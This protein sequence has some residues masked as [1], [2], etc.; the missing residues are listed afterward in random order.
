VAQ[1]RLAALSYA[2]YG[3]LGLGRFGH[4]YGHGVGLGLGH[5]LYRGFH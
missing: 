3:G 5:S 1:S 2:P 4:G